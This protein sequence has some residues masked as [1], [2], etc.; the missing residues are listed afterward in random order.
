M[1][2]SGATDFPPDRGNTILLC[3]ACALQR[4]RSMVRH[5]V[6][7]LGVIA[8]TAASN[9]PLRRLQVSTST[10]LVLHYTARLLAAITAMSLL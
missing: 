10:A 6:L 2:Q 4:D 5:G 1:Q 3:I 9:I 8:L 7:A